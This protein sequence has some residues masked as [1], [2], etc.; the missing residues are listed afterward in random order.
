MCWLRVQDLKGKILVKGKKEHVVE[1][2]SS[3]SDL[4]SSDEEASRAEG[5][6]KGKKE[7]KKVG[8]IPPARL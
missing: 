5:K 6:P 4:S 7:D 2:S 8:A 1:G 3:S